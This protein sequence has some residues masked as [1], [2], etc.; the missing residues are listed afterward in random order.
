MAPPK[1]ASAHAAKKTTKNAAPRA[2]LAPRETGL[3][4]SSNRPLVGRTQ[5]A[6]IDQFL[7]LRLL[8]DHAIELEH[9][10]REIDERLVLLRVVVFVFVAVLPVDVGGGLRESLARLLDATAHQLVRFERVALE[11]VQRLE[12]A[13]DRRL[14]HLRMLVDEVL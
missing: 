6:Q 7:R 12:E 9:S 1:V 14:H 2:I 3:R 13:V 10:H 11:Q 5:E 4:G 8:L